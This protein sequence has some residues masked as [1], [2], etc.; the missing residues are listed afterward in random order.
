[1]ARVTFFLNGFYIDVGA[2]DPTLESVTKAF[3]E[4]GWSGINIEPSPKYYARL[5]AERARD[6]NLPMA[7]SDREGELIFY[8]ASESGR[9]TAS[10]VITW[11]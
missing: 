6:I 5:C 2:N 4:R 1:M 9:S 11:R 7:V 3:Y 10:T 8:D